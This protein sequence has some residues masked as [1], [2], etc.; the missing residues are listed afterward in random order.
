MKRILHLGD[1]H[2][3]ETA[4]IA[5][6]VVLDPSGMNLALLD[7]VQAVHAVVRA[8][9]PLDGVVI[10]GD[11]FD[12]PRPTPTELRVG[13]SLLEWICGA[14]GIPNV[15]VIPGNHDEPRST[16]EATACTPAGWH[17]RVLLV[18]EPRT[19][20]YAGLRIGC[21]PYPRRAALRESLPADAVGDATALLSSALTSIALGLRASG[22]EVL[23]AHASIGGATVGAQPRTL[24]GDIEI[25]RDAL[26]VF[27]AV[28]LGHIHQQQI[29]RQCGYSGS[30]TV[31][32][33]GE[34]GEHKG[35]LLWTIGD[36]EFLRS[37]V[38]APGRTWKTIDLGAAISMT[39]PDLDH[40]TPGGVHRIR[41][42]MSH[43]MLAATRR[44]LATSR[45]GGAFVQDELRLLCEDR[46]R[47]REMGQTGLDDAE[48]V[49]RALA[50]RQ[51]PE[52]DHG[53]L[54][55]LHSHVQQGV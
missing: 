54:V 17:P 38:Q 23:L 6:A 16:S 14:A 20:D 10:A 4:T 9:L 12:R 32:D 40:L 29:I 37:P 51:V 19:V 3:S 50:S 43:D 24:E 45:A 13:T 18:E 49:R 36:G 46:V 44:D 28:L 22:A 52:G 42:E 55:E 25:S 27:P 26:D 8:A 34:E 53:R 33:F 1:L 39:E 2:L 5:G 15:L 7:T 11:L 48:L 35:G 41:G 47:D 21:L 30:P 31:Q